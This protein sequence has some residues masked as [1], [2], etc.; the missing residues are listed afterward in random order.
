MKRTDLVRGLDNDGCV[1]LR[2]GQ[3]HDW[4]QNPGTG[5]CQPVPRHREV[6]ERLARDGLRKLQSRATSRGGGAAG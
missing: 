6:N 5:M 1:L 4:F 2:R 3:R